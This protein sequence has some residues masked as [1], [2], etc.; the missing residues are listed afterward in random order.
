M[1]N[2]CSKEEK[3]SLGGDNIEFCPSLSCDCNT[4]LCIDMK[5]ISPIYP[6]T[7]VLRQQLKMN[8]KLE[9]RISTTM[10]RSESFHLTTRYSSLLPTTAS[11]C[12]EPSHTTTSEE[13]QDT[14]NKKV[15]L[16]FARTIFKTKLFGQACKVF[17]VS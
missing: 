5:G 17:K 10:S 3:M 7:Y 14:K 6:R 11:S 8:I 1:K 4:A 9:P 15:K 2:L 12:H 16:L 13:Q